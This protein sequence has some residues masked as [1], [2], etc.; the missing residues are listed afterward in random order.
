MN[1]S[2]FLTAP[3]TCKRLSEA[4]GEHQTW[5]SQVTRLGIPVPK[6]VSLSTAELKDWAV[7]W[8]K[9]S[10]KLWVNLGYHGLEDRPLSLHCFKVLR[11]DDDYWRTRFIMAKLIPGGRFVVVLYVDGDIDL[12]AIDIKSEGEWEL[13]DVARYRGANLS[14]IWPGEL[15][16]ETNIGRP[17]IAYVDHGGEKYG[18]SFSRFQ[19]HTD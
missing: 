16:T 1:C 5:L 2:L 19:R 11:E 18:H 3:Q 13:R 12:K 15:L 9:P 6:S 8:S 14:A 7:S 10:D 4:S 17:L